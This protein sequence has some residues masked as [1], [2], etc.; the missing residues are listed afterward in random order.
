MGKNHSNSAWSSGK[1]PCLSRADLLRFLGF[2]GEEK[3][4]KAAPFFGY[5]QVQ[6]KVKKPK[7]IPAAKEV[8][9]PQK[10]S[11]EKRHFVQQNEVQ[12]IAPAWWHKAKTLEGPVQADPGKQ[13]PPMSPLIPWPRLW[14]FLREALGDQIQGRSVDMEMLVAQAAQGKPIS[15]IPYRKKRGWARWCQILLDCDDRLQPFWHD[16]SKLCLGIKALRGAN[17]L[18]VLVL[19]EGPD[20]PCRNWQ[21]WLEPAKIYQFPEPETPILIVSDLGLYDS[22][23][24]VRYAWLRFGRRLKRAGFS[25][26]AL[27]HTPPRLWDEELAHCFGLACWDRAERLPHPGK[28]YVKGALPH[29]G[30]VT[31]ANQGRKKLLA[32]L[33]T[34]IRVEPEILRAVRQMLPCDCADVGTEAEVWNHTDTLTTPIA[35]AFVSET[36]PAHR[37]AFRKEK[38]SLQREVL[39]CIRQY[40]AHLSPSVIHEE[41]LLADNLVS[42]GAE[43]ARGHMQ[44]VARTLSSQNFLYQEPLMAWLRRL[45]GRQH[46]EMWQQYEELATAWAIVNKDDWEKGHINLP[47]G[48]DMAKVAWILST[49]GTIRSYLIRRRGHGFVVSGEPPTPSGTASEWADSGSPVARLSS[50]ASYLEIAY[51]EDNR[52]VNQARFLNSLHEIILPV[53]ESLVITLRTDHEE[54]ILESLEKP[55][56]AQGIGRDQ[57]GLYADFSFKSIVQRMRW[58]KPDI[59]RMGSPEDEPKRSDREVMHEVVLTRGFWLAETACTQALWEA[60]IGENPSRFK[61]FNRP[62]ERVSW[63]DAQD[64]IKKI[65]SKKDDLNL[66]LPTEAEWEYACRAGTTTPF[67]FGENITPNQVNYDGNY[68]YAGGKKGKYRE[69]TVEVKSL[70]CNGWGLYEM[71]GNVWEW[72]ADWYGDYPPELVVDPNGPDRGD[73]RVLR[74]G[75]WISVGRD[76]RSASPQLLRA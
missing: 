64:F 72:C 35:F 54:I 21:K 20:G 19:E 11:Q 43:A 22:T 69:E 47:H 53:P 76:V 56:W 27:T 58:I 48:L 52:S 36:L 28:R 44:S 17:G 66:R 67:Y 12:N 6:K 9:S 8:K 38:E 59:F 31:D 34:A 63:N 16:L 40:H 57:N 13:P 3:L 25:P 61:G 2:F 39:T 15:T 14:P 26:V 74:G 62:V 51:K 70:P 4:I 1:R 42:T 73:Y 68:P 37:D 75:S 60:V 23:E 32:L 65:N 49:P 71:H 7:V 33:S 50:A 30:K 45:F 5:H 41:E 24:R 55:S 29:T 18:E 10:Q 46:P